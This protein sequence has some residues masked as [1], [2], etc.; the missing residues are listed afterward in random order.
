MKSP[1]PAGS[2]SC[3]AAR[4]SVAV[5]F[6]GGGARGLAHIHVIEALDELGIRP[7][8]ISGSSIGAIMGAAMASGMSG[9]D[10][11]D[12]ATSLLSSKAEV[13]SRIWRAQRSFGELLEG[14]L[15][16]GRFNAERILKEFLPEH[17]P[18]D[19]ED[20]KIPLHVTGTDYYGH[21][22]AVFDS[23][24]LVSAI[25]SSIALPAVFEPV[26]RD[27]MTLIDG[28]ICNPLPYDVLKGKADIVVAIDVVG[29]PC[30]NAGKAPS[31]IELLF[32]TSQLMMQSI[33][34]MQLQISEP[35]I[36]LRPPVGRFRV[37]DFLK[38]ETI[39]QET[40][41]LKEELKQRLDAVF[42]AKMS[43]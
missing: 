27:G 35:D 3:S 10:I 22:L 14:G 28:G 19:F 5:A 36:L 11:R 41:F 6:G 40:A 21:K 34:K 13:A 25:A 16:F 18:S 37:L 39:M 29:F 23:G 20:L 24:D 38:I 8:A 9:Q 4:P 12:Y 43:V 15:H 32:G 2:D 30:L 33:L 17:V 42:S 1:V 26:E 7:V 31:T